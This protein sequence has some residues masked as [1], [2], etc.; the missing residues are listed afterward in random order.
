MFSKVEGFLKDDNFINCAL[1]VFPEINAFQK[2]V[3]IREHS[4]YSSCA[5]EAK[6]ILLAPTD[7]ACGFSPEDIQEVKNRLFITIALLSE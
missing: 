7:V 5:E 6:A 2:E 4:G 3:F 1:G